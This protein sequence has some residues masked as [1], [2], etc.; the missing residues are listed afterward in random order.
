MKSSEIEDLRI[1]AQACSIWDQVWG[2]QDIESLM[3]ALHGNSSNP[4]IETHLPHIRKLLTSCKKG[5]FVLDAG[6]GL[7]QWVFYAEEMGHK[8][9]GIDIALGT[10][11]RAKKWGSSQAF[12]IEFVLGDVRRLPF[13]DEVLDYVFSFGVIEHFHNP[14]NLLKE[15]YRVLSLEGKALVTTPNIFCSHTIMRL[16]QRA[17]GT[18]VLGY[19]TSY[20]PSRLRKICELGGFRV[21]TGGVM[22]GGEL[23][24]Y[25]AS[26]IPLI[27]RK[28]H[29]LLMKI[30]LYIE[31]KTEILGFWSFAI[32]RKVG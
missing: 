29:K 12:S 2:K 6:C 32:C 11:Q 28:L 1:R 31:K 25:A 10:L 9:V 22:P 19:E 5:S 23:F 13:R 26:Y 27:G 4:M 16:V 7:G 18:W 24:G 14:I 30:A 21:E 3:G 15:M 20:S 17:L 8:A